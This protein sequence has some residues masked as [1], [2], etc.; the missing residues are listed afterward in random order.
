M[1]LDSLKAQLCIIFISTINAVTADFFGDASKYRK[2]EYLLY[3]IIASQKNLPA[4][5]ML[6]PLFERKEQESLLKLAC[7]FKGTAG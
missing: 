7:L 6:R 4:K 3:K 1:I 5:V 2:I